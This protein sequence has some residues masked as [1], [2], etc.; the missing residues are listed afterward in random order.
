MQMNNTPSHKTTSWKSYAAHIAAMV[1][2]T[3]AAVIF[4]TV[5]AGG[6]NALHL[7]TS[8]QPERFTEL[9]FD[10]TLQ[11]PTTVTAGRRYSFSF[12]ITNQEYET[13]TYTPQVSLVEPHATIPVRTYTFA[14][15]QG[16]QVD[17]TVYF[18]APYAGTQFEVKV[19]LPAQNQSIYFRSQS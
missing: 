19:T 5:T 18:I 1:G 9:Y 7:A 8:K 14:L 12:H 2:I 4:F 16:N 10:N 3:L 15:N 6:V 13:T 11:L 17:Q